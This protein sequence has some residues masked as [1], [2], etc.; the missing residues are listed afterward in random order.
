[1]PR[2][3]RTLKRSFFTDERL[4]SVPRAVRLTFQGLIANADDYGRLRA[5]P[6]LL[7]AAIYPL[8]DDITSADMRKEIEQLEAIGCVR[9]YEAAGTRYLEI[10]NFEKHQVMARKYGS[11][12]PAPSV[13]S[14]DS[15]DA[16]RAQGVHTAGEERRG[17][18]EE[19]ERSGGFA[20]LPVILV[21]GT[22]SLRSPQPDDDYE[23]PASLM[24]L[25][26]PEAH[27]VLATFYEFPA[28]SHS[29]RKRYK[30]VA[31]QLCDAMDPKH[32]GPKVSGGQRVKAR[33]VAHLADVCRSVLKDPPMDRDV[34]IVLVLKKLLD[35]PKGPSVTEQMAH[36]DA[37]TRREEDEYDRDARSA[38]IAWAEAH[39]DEYA[40]ILA[41]VD[42]SYAGKA[43]AFVKV[44]RLAELTRRCAQACGF[45][46]FEKW[47]RQPQ[48][49]AA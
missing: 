5:D 16:V 1:M 12:I 6:R 32:P 46:S 37:A 30:A 11:D 48:A 42:A 3:I 19:K 38:G 9:H 34:A 28:M 4:C 44:A 23:L 17:E 15:A 7:K 2:E 13:E 10:A 49:G 24:A 22:S 26:P 33:S 40:P 20:S 35:P 41:S 25:L 8:D 29:Q 31:L 39:P 21:Q 43:G 18:G 36:S 47:Q 45:P 27:Q 14:V